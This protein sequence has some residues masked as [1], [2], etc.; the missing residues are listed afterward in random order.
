M[1]RIYDRLDLTRNLRSSNI[2]AS[3]SP[4]KNSFAFMRIASFYVQRVITFEQTSNDTEQNNEN[5]E[6]RSAFFAKR[7]KPKRGASPNT[8]TCVRFSSLHMEAYFDMPLFYIKKNYLD[9]R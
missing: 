5:K 8:V 6:S 4:L 9:L 7:L 1:N 3:T 2:L